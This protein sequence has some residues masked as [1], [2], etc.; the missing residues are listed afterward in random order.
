VSSS[1]VKFATDRFQFTHDAVFRIN[2]AKYRAKIIHIH[3]ELKQSSKRS[4]EEWNMIR[5]AFFIRENEALAHEIDSLF[6]AWASQTNASKQFDY[7]IERLSN[8]FNML[9]RAEQHTFFHSLQEQPQS[10]PTIVLLSVFVMIALIYKALKMFR[11]ER[12]H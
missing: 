1:G 6:R 5:S 3:Q 2:Q 10:I 7:I 8:H 9:T 4:I 11:A 12:L